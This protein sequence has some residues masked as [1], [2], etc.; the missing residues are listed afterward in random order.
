MKGYLV[1]ADENDMYTFGIATCTIPVPDG[2]ETLQFTPESLPSALA[3]LQEY[4]YIF[5]EHQDTPVADI[6]ESKTLKGVKYETGIFNMGETLEKYPELKKLIPREYRDI[7]FSTVQCMTILGK[8]KNDTTI[9]K[10]ARESIQSGHL[11]GMSIRGMATDSSLECK[12]KE[13]VNKISKLELWSVVYCI[14]PKHHAA[15]VIPISNSEVV[16]M[17]KEKNPADSEVKMESFEECV[18][19]MR[20][21]VDD[22][23]AYCATICRK[24]GM[25]EGETMTEKKEGCESCD[26]KEQV[27]QQDE[28]PSPTVEE[29]MA[30]VMTRLDSFEAR[31]SAL[32]GGPPTEEETQAEPPK[33][34]EKLGQTTQTVDIE[35]LIQQAVDKAV[36]AV[37][38]TDK[39]DVKLADELAQ[40]PKQK[41]KIKPVGFAGL[42]KMSEEQKE[43]FIESLGGD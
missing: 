37:R 8:L 39:K 17:E 42:L 26:K 27:K 33:E 43:E 23:E 41:E 36:E 16:N 25:T 2:G 10:E 11:T 28:T 21:K 13:C 19:R 3:Q 9:A 5:L 20:G 38:K 14:N 7:D 6:L 12:G 31:L 40:P 30:Q 1:F 35:K 22:P 34:P 4:G 18:A 29:L 15:R 24:K 32:E